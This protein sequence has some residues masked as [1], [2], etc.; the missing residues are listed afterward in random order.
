[1]NKLLPKSFKTAA[2]AASATLLAIPL[3]AAPGFASPPGRAIDLAEMQARG[4]ERF[5]ALDQ[6]NDG[7]VSQQEYLE[8]M[9]V[10]GMHRKPHHEGERRKGER[11]KETRHEESEASVFA[12]LDTDGNGQLSEAEFEQRHM[13]R[14]RHVQAH[15][16][17]RF[18][19]LDSNKDNS[20]S[21]EE[22]QAK[23]EKMR[24]LDSDGDGLVT[25]EEMRAQRTSARAL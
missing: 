4:A 19:A 13:L 15:R 24:S 1:M 3:I 10:P 2:I 8:A 23:L 5:A 11:H 18:E 17:S 25:R 21:L 16:Q 20:L 14:Q 7:L 22:L 12:Q 9:P 6:N